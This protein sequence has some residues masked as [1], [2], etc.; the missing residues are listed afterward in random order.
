MSPN[1]VQKVPYFQMPTAKVFQTDGLGVLIDR[2]GHRLLQVFRGGAQC[3]AFWGG[4]Q[5]ICW[6]TVCF[7]SWFA[8]GQK[9]ENPR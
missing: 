9:A 2:W 3:T 5:Q 7:L 6:V 1:E 8:V 4:S